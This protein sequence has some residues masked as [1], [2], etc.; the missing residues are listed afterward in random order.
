MSNQ[1]KLNDLL[2]LSDEEIQIAKIKF[3]QD[4]GEEDPM[5]AYLNDPDLIN[6]GWLFW[7]KKQRYFNVGQIAICFLKLSFDTWLLTTIK[8][9]TK[10]LNVLHDINYEGE[11]V[12]KYKGYYGRVI[13]KFHKKTQS[14]GYKAKTIIDKLEVLEVL[15]TTFDGDVFKG[16]EQVCLS[17][18]Q[19]EVVIKRRKKDWVA[20]L[21]NQ[22][23]VYLVTD[24]SN[25]KMY[26]GSA[27]GSNGMLLDRW[28]NYISNGHGNNAEL[29]EVIKLNGIEYA[30]QN[31]QFS[32]LENYNSRIDSRVI[33]ERE[34]WWKKVL[35]TRFFGYNSN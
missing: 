30:K 5:E 15:P 28:E 34:S 21:E 31:F 14:Q 4:N 9:V 13:V 7:R 17:F 29:I 11:E 1:I 25:G 2:K 6:N 19:L 24:K 32:I 27:Y 10:E 35:L 16:Y 33:I 18:T 3:N 20:A 12:V 8:I 22:K 23:G 26:V